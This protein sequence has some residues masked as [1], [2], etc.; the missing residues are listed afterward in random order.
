LAELFQ[1][2]LTFEEVEQSLKKYTILDE[3][4]D[5]GQGVVFQGRDIL[6]GKEVAIKVYSPQQMIQR[7]ELEVEKLEKINSPFLAK[8]VEHDYTL[9]RGENCYYVVTEYIQGRDLKKILAE[10]QLTEDEVKTLMTHMLLALEQLWNLR[11]VHCDIKPPNILALHSGEYILIDLGYAK[12]LDSETITMAGYIMGTM[13]YMAPE[14][15][16]GRKNLTVRAD[17]FALGIIAYEAL[18]G[19][20]PF[21]KNQHLIFNNQKASPVEDYVDIDENL[22]KAINWMLNP[23][24]I[25]RPVST[26]QVLRLIQEGE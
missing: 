22:A 11:V 6:T 26:Q 1:P 20:H 19:L 18:T 15:L 13:G 16:K 3:L 5:G 25:R 8:V 21:A 17:M 14:H 10:R 24:P 12:H 9:L 2:K 7:A 23:N 4:G